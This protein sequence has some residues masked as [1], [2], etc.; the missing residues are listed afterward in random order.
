MRM[1]TRVLLSATTDAVRAERTSASGEVDDEIG[2]RSRVGSRTAF[3]ASPR[4]AR[5]LRRRS[6]RWGGAPPPCKTFEAASSPEI[7]LDRRGVSGAIAPRGHAD[8]SCL[9]TYS[10][11]RLGRLQRLTGLCA[12]S[13][14][15]SGVDKLRQDLRSPRRADVLRL[16]PL[17]I[18]RRGVCVSLA[19]S[20]QAL[21]RLLGLGIAHGRSRAPA[22]SSTSAA[23]SRAIET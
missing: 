1:Q 17:L 20:R 21:R 6:R 12:R 10:R 23:G 9:R 14:R 22:G 16:D 5:T 2:R 7:L 19:H 8:R 18:S 13:W 4:A 15:R 11:Q 3:C